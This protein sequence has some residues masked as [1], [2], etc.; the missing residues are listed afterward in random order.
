[1]ATK[2]V[3]HAVIAGHDGNIWAQSAGFTVSLTHCSGSG[4]GSRSGRIRNF[5]PDPI[6]NRNKHFGSG[7]ESGFESR[8]ETG[9]EINQKKL[10]LYSGKNKAVSYDYTYFTFTRCTLCLC[11]S[12]RFGWAQ[13]KQLFCKPK[14]RICF[15]WGESNV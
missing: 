2:F 1:M 13:D 5:W 11:L 4:N 9:S 12:R 7:F 14:K 10:A 8:S 15:E 3:N 6:R